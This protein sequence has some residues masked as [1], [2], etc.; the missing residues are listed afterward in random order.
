[1]FVGLKKRRFGGRLFFVLACMQWRNGGSGR[2][3]RASPF[4]TRAKRQHNRETGQMTHGRPYETLLRV[5]TRNWRAACMPPLQRQQAVC[6]SFVGADIIR[7]PHTRKPE[8]LY[9]LRRPLSNLPQPKGAANKKA[10]GTV[11]PSAAFD[12][13]PIIKSYPLARVTRQIWGP[14][15]QPLAPEAPVIPRPAQRS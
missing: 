13:V 3:E 7:P 2:A 15:V 6:P 8:A 9:C 11:L 5:L 14:G 4:P 12:A 10:E 1:M